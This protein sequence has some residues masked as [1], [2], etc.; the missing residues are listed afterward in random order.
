M[1]MNG[2]TRRG[3][4]AAIS[5]AA[6]GLTKLA[7]LKTWAADAGHPT[8]PVETASGKV[9]GMRAAGISTFLGIPYGADTSSCRFQ[10]ARAPQPWTGVRDCFTF[11]HRAPQLVNRMPGAS[12]SA[13]MTPAARFLLN[14]TSHASMGSPQGED[15]LVLN[16]WTP[17]ASSRRKRPVMIRI[18][19][20]AWAVGSGETEDLSALC[21][22]GDI[23][24]VAMNHRINAL[25]YLYLG[26]FHDDFVDSGNV[27]Q[28]DLV[29]ALQ[30]VRDNIA[31]FGGDPDN[32]TISGE[33]GGGWKTGALLGCVPAKGLFHKA[34]EE[35]GSFVAAV[36]LS[37]AVEVAEQTLKAL[38]IAKADVHDLQKLDCMRVIEAALSV[39]PS[40]AEA[41][42]LVLR[43]LAPAL[44]G[45]S[46]PAHPFK[47]AA[48]ELS[49]HI[50]LIIGSNK[51]EATLMMGFDSNFGTY[52]AD[53][54]QKQ[55]TAMLG[56]ERG[57]RAFEIY[58]N[59]AA[60][61]Q[62]TYWLSAISTDIAFRIGSIVEAER[63]AAQNA[64]PV[65]MYRFDYEAP[66]AGGVLRAFHGAE[67][68]FV[69]NGS[70]SGEM[71][72]TGPEQQGLADKMSQAWLNFAHTGN[73]S[74]K[75]L[76]WPR[77]D[78]IS[79]KTML[80]NKQNEAVSDPDRTTRVFWTA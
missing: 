10:P 49:R 78:G 33:S 19:G 75:G 32:V 73:P 2:I 58:R 29:L 47:P 60:D 66:V 42:P 61:D 37:D 15:C 40:R 52:T 1:A 4:I 28:L 3:A 23:V 5:G 14:I 8:A 13:N 38:G 79:R 54:V 67:V 24:G 21:R 68:S 39:S 48:T 77:Y 59:R 43:G 71:A 56:A 64:A 18:H 46:M 7:T 31:A 80:F 74:Q 70:V 34:I 44:D 50:P 22:K 53:A 41:D 65:F 20:G 57:A 63:K 35:S 12:A 45:R 27:G 9:R 11:G 62:P 26:A 69:L 6:I 17:E 25:G 72:P 51:D 76:E 55:F 16:V 36:E 30:W